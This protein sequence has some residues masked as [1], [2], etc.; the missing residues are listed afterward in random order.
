MSVK[1]HVNDDEKE[2]HELP[3]IATLPEGMMVAVDSERTGTKSFNLTAALEEKASTEDVEAIE[4]DMEGKVDSPSTT[5]TAGQVLMFDGTDNVWS[6]PPEGVYVL[7]YTEVSDLNDSRYRHYC[8]NSYIRI[9]LH[10]ISA[11]RN[12]HGH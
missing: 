5:P 8:N 6:D 4:T 7:N 2:I 12:S 11:A 3:E 1:Q 10:G 9:T